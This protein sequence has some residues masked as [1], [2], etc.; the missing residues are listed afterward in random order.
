MA[1]G[2]VFAGKGQPIIDTMN[3]GSGVNYAT[4]LDQAARTIANVDIVIPGHA[5]PL[6]WQDFQEFGEFNRL[7]LAHARE[8]VKA[9]QTPVQAMESFRNA[10]PPRFK[11][12]SLGAGM[13]T[14]PGGNFEPIFREL[15]PR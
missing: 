1:T 13:M 2:D 7:F 15:Q 12:Y 3:G 9:G 11:G 4:V 5:A 14:G 10:V 6:T 8:A